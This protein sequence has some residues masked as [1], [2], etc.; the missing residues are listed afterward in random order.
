MRMR[1]AMRGS[2]GA[3]V[4]LHGLL[5]LLGAA[6]GL[7]WAKVSQLSEPVSAAMGAAW[8]VGALLVVGAGVLLA[9]PSRWWW[10]LGGSAA[11]VSQALISTS[12][13][14][15]RA[16]TA[17]GVAWTLSLRPPAVAAQMLLTCS[18]PRTP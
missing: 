1:A 13:S 17:I 8:L 16:G 14:D 10:V 7:G 4:V 12:W 6:K 15:A 3:V 2:L 18:S 9:V 11:V 5:H